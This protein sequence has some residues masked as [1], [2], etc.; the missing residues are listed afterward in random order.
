MYHLATLVWAFS[1]VST[2]GI[3]HCMKSYE[4]SFSEIV[5]IQSVTSVTGNVVKKRPNVPQNYKILRLPKKIRAFEDL[6]QSII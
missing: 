4:N 5:N 3:T 6:L 2:F 1:E